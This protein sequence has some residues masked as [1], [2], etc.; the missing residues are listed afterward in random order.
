[1]KNPTTVFRKL[2]SIFAS[3]L[4]FLIQGNN[5]L[6]F[7]SNPHRL[8]PR[9]STLASIEINW[10]K[11]CSIQGIILDLDNTI[12]SEDDQYLS[13]CA[14]DWITQA[15]LAGLQFFILSNGKRRYR[16]KYWSH[17]LDI[18][19][20]SPA[21]KPFPPAFQQAIAY[22]QLPAKRILVIGDSLHTDFVGALLSG[23]SYIQVASLPHPP[24]WWE[25][26]AGRWVQI[27]YPSGGELWDFD[28]A[29]GYE[30]FF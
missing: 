23:C 3:W 1:M 24:R 27:S 15:K 13:P 2:F 4:H 5:Q 29:A 16:V 8:P 12:V 21:K 6:G 28:S 9:A 26:L 11:T 14:E 18:P 20:L 10:L 30:S 25:K 22:M 17:R 19:A 7:K